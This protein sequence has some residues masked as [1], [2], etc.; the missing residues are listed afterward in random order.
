MING[1]VSLLRQIPE[2]I[3]D[4]GL[5]FIGTDYHTGY[6]SYL[7]QKGGEHCRRKLIRQILFILKNFV[8]KKVN[9]TGN[10]TGGKI[11]ETLTLGKIMNKA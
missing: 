8:K 11:K 6:F 10:D 9:R 7:S 3:E 2:E 1:E 4:I 5:P